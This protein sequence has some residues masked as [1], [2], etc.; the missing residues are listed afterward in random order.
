MAATTA[1]ALKATVEGFGLGLA[2]FRDRAPDGQGGV[3]VVIHES[4]TRSSAGHG[5]F[6]DPT[7]DQAI[8]EEVQLD[9]YEPALSDDKATVAES[10]T[11]RDDLQRRLHGC[12][13]PSAPKRV[14]GCRVLN[15]SRVPP[16]PGD[17][18]N[19]VRTIFTLALSRAL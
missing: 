18:T 16:A 13:I 6:G 14:H 5:D 19:K 1:G 11:L 9:L 10:P 8:V 4:I 2:A 12:Q 15:A 17:D 3:Y 7:A